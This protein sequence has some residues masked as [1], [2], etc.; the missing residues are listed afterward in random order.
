MAMVAAGLGVT[1][2]SDLGMRLRPPGID[3]V[4]LTTPLMRTVSIAYRTTALRRHALSL[5]IE[6]VRASAA[7]LG[8]GA[9][10]ALP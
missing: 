6:A 10:S 3:I 4:T 1:L 7:E 9:E 2:V 5:V 8:L